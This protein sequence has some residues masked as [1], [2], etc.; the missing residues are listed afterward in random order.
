MTSLLTELDPEVE[1]SAD[2]EQIDPPDPCPET[3][4]TRALCVCCQ[5]EDFDA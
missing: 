1:D 2:E 3:S 5:L 4:L